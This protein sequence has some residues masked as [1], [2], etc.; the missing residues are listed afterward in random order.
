L[1]LWFQGNRQENLPPFKIL[2][3]TDL[4]SKKESKTLSEWRCTMKELKCVLGTSWKENP[5]SEEIVS[6]YET[7]LSFLP[8]VEPT[9]TKR[10]RRVG[11]IHLT[12]ALKL[13]RKNRKA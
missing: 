10:R 12:T 13:I 1:Q 4:N 8:S 2:E 11:Q 9:T 5:T 3:Y 7:A 6:M